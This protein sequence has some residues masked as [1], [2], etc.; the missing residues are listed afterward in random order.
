MKRDERVSTQE[1]QDELLLNLDGIFQEEFLIRRL[2]NAVYGSFMFNVR[3]I[4]LC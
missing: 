4:K 1:R 3:V 2:I